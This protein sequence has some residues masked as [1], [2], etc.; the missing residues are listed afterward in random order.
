MCVV[1]VREE[2][3]CARRGKRCV[4]KVAKCE[5]RHRVMRCDCGCVCCGEVWGEAQSDEMCCGCVCWGNCV[6]S[7]SD[8]TRCVDVRWWGVAGVGEKWEKGWGC[9][10][11]RRVVASVWVRSKSDETRWGVRMVGC[12]RSRRVAKRR[13]RA[14]VYRTPMVGWTVVFD[15]VVHS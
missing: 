14:T 9:A 2:V 1:S 7:K 8:G 13:V 5:V 4:E 11:A 3:G 12:S 6:R 10:T 15:R